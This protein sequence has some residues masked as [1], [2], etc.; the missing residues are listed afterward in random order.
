MIFF[1]LQVDVENSVIA[2]NQDNGLTEQL[3]SLKRRVAAERVSK[4]P[5][6]R[7]HGLVDARAAATIF[8]LMLHLSKSWTLHAIILEKCIE[9]Y[10]SL[11]FNPK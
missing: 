1:L 5:E 11:I 10:F 8:D 4:S 2:N 7:F 6:H 3:E 9:N